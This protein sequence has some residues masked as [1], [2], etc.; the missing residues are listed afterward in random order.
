MPGMMPSNSYAVNEIQLANP[1]RMSR[2][3]AIAAAIAIFAVWALIGLT[4]SP[5]FTIDE[6]PIIDAGHTFQ[7]L[8]YLAIRTAGPGSHH[9]EDAYLAQMPL[10]PVVLGIWFKLFGFDSFKPACSR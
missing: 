1:R 3:Q 5:G 10:H 6:S 4:S 8:G 2:S 7:E 9:Y